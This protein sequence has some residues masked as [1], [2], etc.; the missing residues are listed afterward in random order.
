MLTHKHIHNAAMHIALCFFVGGCGNNKFSGGF[1]GSSNPKQAQPPQDGKV[2]VLVP[3]LNQLA[4]ATAASCG[5]NNKTG[6][7]LSEDITSP[8]YTK[9][10]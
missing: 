6:C 9:Y 8:L 10:K 7:E 4:H 1:G 5:G 2:D 3:E